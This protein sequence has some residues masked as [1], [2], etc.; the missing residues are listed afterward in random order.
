MK[1]LLSIFF[2][3]HGHIVIFRIQKDNRHSAK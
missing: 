2:R 1:S 3:I